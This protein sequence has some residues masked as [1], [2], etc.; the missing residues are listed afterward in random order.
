LKIIVISIF[1]SLL[2]GCSKPEIIKTKSELLRN[3]EALITG[4]NSS[5]LSDLIGLGARLNIRFVEL[6]KKKLDSDPING[7]PTSLI[8]K[9]GKHEFTVSCFGYFDSVQVYNPL[10]VE[11]DAKSGR[12]YLLRPYLSKWGCEAKF[13]DVTDK[14]S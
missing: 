8:V 14:K 4:Y 10:T 12:K 1:L 3:K 11:L 9:E 7:L 2:V 13:L 5:F 6:N